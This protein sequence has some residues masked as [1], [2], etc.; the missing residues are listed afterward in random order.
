MLRDGAYG[1]NYTQ[2]QGGLVERNPDNAP[3]RRFGVA[4]MG[5]FASQ[6]RYQP[7]AAK[8]D[9][10]SSACGYLYLV[11]EGSMSII[12]QNENGSESVVFGVRPPCHGNIGH[13]GCTA[14]TRVNC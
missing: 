6:S 14:G 9:I 11:P 13:I 7:V 2:R 12:T 1:A 5:H 8:T 10:T 3:M 4:V